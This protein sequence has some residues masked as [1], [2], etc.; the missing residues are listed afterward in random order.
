MLRAE[1]VVLKPGAVECPGRETLLWLVL[2]RKI[3]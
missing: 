1:H 3:S 2:Q